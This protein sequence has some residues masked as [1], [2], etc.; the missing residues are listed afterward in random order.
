MARHVWHL[1]ILSPCPFEIICCDLLFQDHIRVLW[2]N[3]S[4]KLSLFL[5]NLNDKVCMRWSVVR[6]FLENTLCIQTSEIIC[7]YVW[8]E[9]MIWYNMMCWYFDICY[10]I[11]S[12]S[13]ETIVF[14]VSYELLSVSC[15]ALV[16]EPNL[17][18]ILC[19]ECFSVQLGFLQMFWCFTM[20]L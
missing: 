7:I 18:P 3:F 20:Y 17:R 14:R 8:F 12:L 1:F 4:H 19:F 2:G 10:N 5:N 11:C 13:L 15:E 6:Q 9:Y 16:G